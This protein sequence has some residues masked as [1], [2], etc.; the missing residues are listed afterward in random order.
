MVNMARCLSLDDVLFVSRVKDE[1]RVRLLQKSWALC[2]PS[3]VEGWGLVITEAAACGTP[4]VAYD[5]G[6]RS[7]AIVDGETGYLVKNV[8]IQVISE[9]IVVLNQNEQL[10]RSMSNAAVVY[11][12]CFE[13]DTS[14]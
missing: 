6:G 3:F 14:A 10:R 9:R 5:G 12:K 4:A 11:A 7:V 8:D 13:W 2:T 1:E